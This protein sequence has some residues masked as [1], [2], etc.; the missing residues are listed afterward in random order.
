[1]PKPLR[2][3]AIF[4]AGCVLFGLILLPAA[5]FVVGS[6][7][8]GEFGNGGFKDFATTLYSALG[9][10]D[11]VVWFLILS[12]YLLFQ[13]LRWTFRLFRSTKLN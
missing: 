3:E 5:V 7:V 1:M 11:P 10:F 8:F 12:P 9:K 13:S 4:F 6:T 2:R